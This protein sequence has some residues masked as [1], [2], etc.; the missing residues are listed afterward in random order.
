MATKISLQCECLSTV[1]ATKTKLHKLCWYCWWCLLLLGT[2]AAAVWTH[3]GQLKH[4]GP[5]GIQLNKF[6]IAVQQEKYGYVGGTQAP[7]LPPPP[8]P[9]SQP[10]PV[11]PVSM[12]ALLAVCARL[13]LHAPG[14]HVARG[15]C[16][17]GGWAC[18]QHTRSGLRWLGCSPPVKQQQHG[19]PRGATLWY[20]GRLGGQNTAHCT[21]CIAARPTV[22]SPP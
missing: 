9:F 14:Y 12:L 11:L 15:L 3:P 19:R 1:L 13:D 5:C 20:V 8:L 6:L 4:N 16:W 18:R 10:P 22:C 17:L 21:E 2:V 7:P